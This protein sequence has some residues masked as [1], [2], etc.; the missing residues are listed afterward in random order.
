MLKKEIKHYVKFSAP[1]FPERDSVIHRYCSCKVLPFP[2]F[3][4][5]QR[6]ALSEV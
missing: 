4:K 5:E 3:S 1:N 6:N 2:V